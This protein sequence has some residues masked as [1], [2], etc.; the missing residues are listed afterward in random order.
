MC[1]WT[2]V[3]RFSRLRLLLGLVL[4][5]GVLLPALPAAAIVGRDDLAHPGDYPY[6]G[7]A[8]LVLNCCDD[9]G[10]PF[11]NPIPPDLSQS[12]RDNTVRTTG[13]L[14]S[15]NVF[16]TEGAQYRN[17]RRVAVTF[18][19]PIT[20]GDFTDIYNRTS[21]PGGTTF[22]GYVFHLPGL[23]RNDDSTYAGF[24]LAAIVLDFP[25]PAS[26]HVP[27]AK[28][29]AV[30]ALDPTK[31]AKSQEFTAISYG[32]NNHDPSTWD[33]VRR[34]SSWQP[35]KIEATSVHF[36]GENHDYFVCDGDQGAPFLNKAGEV[37]ALLY[38]GPTFCDK[39]QV[40]D[41][42]RVD[43]PLVRQFLC[44]VGTEGYLDAAA[45]PNPNYPLLGD[46]GALDYPDVI[47]PSVLTDI[48]CDG[49]ANAQATAA[50]KHGH[51]GADRHLRHN[52]AH[53]GKQGGKHHHRS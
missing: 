45:I 25:V 47:N 50:D 8:W 19:N 1:R 11:P 17:G 46:A 9:K 28:L 10:N 42:Y 32:P 2:R 16:L 3:E 33:F 14:I 49:S 53:K 41:G 40:A 24:D 29:A 43:T 20:R 13:V 30:G 26:A 52:H 23:D 31:K 6:V 22:E 18:Q 37:A 34:S 51:Q 35:K 7:A 15:P 12:D 44:N 36:K 4:T 21:N 38:I 39:N 27:F 48:Y 5:L